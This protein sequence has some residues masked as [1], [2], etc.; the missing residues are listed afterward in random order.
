MFNFHFTYNGFTGDSIERFIPPTAGGNIEILYAKPNGPPG[1]GPRISPLFF[2]HGGMGGAWVWQ[3]YLQNLSARGIPCYTISMRD[4][5]NSWHP[6]YLRIVYGTKKR[7][8]ANDVVAGIRWAQEREGGNERVLVGH[9]SGGGLSQFILSE[10]EVK[11]KGLALVA[12]VPGSGSVRVY[13]NWWCLD[14]WFT[15]RMILHGWHPNSPLSH[16]ALTRRVFFSEQPSDA[17]VESFQKR[18]SPYE[19]FLWPL[20]MSYPFTNPQ[21]LLQQITGSEAGQKVLVLWDGPDKIMTLPVMERLAAFY[22]EAYHRLVGKK[23]LDVGDSEIKAIAGEGDQ[24]T[25]GR[26]VRLCIVPGAGH[27]LQNDVQWEAGAQKLL[28]FCE[29]L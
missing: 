15:L 18:V 24:D 7:M 19:S 4:H 22:R 10:Q 3:E 27:H 16:P 11:V 9:C 12:A 20:G 1:H 17:Y 25:A 13:W 26:G 29:Q 21:K 8:L 14:P 28:E 23:K 5:G 2:V 6:S